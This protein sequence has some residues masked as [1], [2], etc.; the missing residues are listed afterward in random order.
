MVSLLGNVTLKPRASRMRTAGEVGL[1]F[2]NGSFWWRGASG[3]C[4]RSLSIVLP[5]AP[6]TGWSG[7][8]D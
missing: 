6:P 3:G 7:N 2:L 1:I 4:A 5:S 8:L